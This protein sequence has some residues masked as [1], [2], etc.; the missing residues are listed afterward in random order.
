[1]KN[2]TYIVVR[3]CKYDDQSF[4]ICDECIKK[5]LPIKNR[6]LTKK[7]DREC[8]CDYCGKV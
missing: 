4:V 7:A 1:M 6:V 5:I 3:E 8:E 2:K